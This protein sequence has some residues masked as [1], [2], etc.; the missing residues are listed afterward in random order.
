[1]VVAHRHHFLTV[2]F[3]TAVQLNGPFA[4]IYLPLGTDGTFTETSSSTG[5]QLLIMDPFEGFLDQMNYTLPSAGSPFGTLSFDQFYEDFSVEPPIEVA[6]QGISEQVILT[7]TPLPTALPLF[8]GGLGLL[9][10]FARRRKQKASAVA[11]A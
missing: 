1:V 5:V 3:I 8:A 10:M 6:L 7:S 11:A 2:P 4:P 9:G